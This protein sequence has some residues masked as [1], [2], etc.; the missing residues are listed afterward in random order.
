VEINNDPWVAP[1]VGSSTGPIKA[2]IL[3]YSPFDAAPKTSQETRRM[4]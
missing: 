4:T 3:K 2:G 1:D